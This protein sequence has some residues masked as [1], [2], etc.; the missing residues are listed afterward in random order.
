MNDMA[1]TYLFDLE[2]ITRLSENGH[3]YGDL[4]FYAEALVAEQGRSDGV[5]PYMYRDLEEIGL[6]E[7]VSASYYIACVRT[8]DSYA[9]IDNRLLQKRYVLFNPRVKAG[10]GVTLGGW[11]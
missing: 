2:T 6:E 3:L 5:L 11:S 1:G 7:M 10:R 8:D 9:L 4:K